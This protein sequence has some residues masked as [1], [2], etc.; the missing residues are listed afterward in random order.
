MNL[1]EI[2]QAINNVNPNNVSAV[3]AEVVAYIWGCS[4]NKEVM[5]VWAL[6]NRTGNMSLIMGVHRDAGMRMV[7]AGRSAP[8]DDKRWNKP[9]NRKHGDLFKS[10]AAIPLTLVG[11]TDGAA[12]CTV[13]NGEMVMYLQ[14]IDETFVAVL[15]ENQKYMCLRMFLEEA[16]GFF[17]KV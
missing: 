1:E 10:G 13:E 7:A 11:C 12:N 2:K 15:H 17:Y 3:V 16:E 6:A 14:D 4:N 9:W 5:E 8:C